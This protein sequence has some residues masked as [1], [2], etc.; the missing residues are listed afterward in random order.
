MTDRAAGPARAVIEQD[1]VVFTS[2]FRYNESVKAYYRERNPD[3]PQYVGTPAPEI[4]KA[5][6]ELLMGM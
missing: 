4:D 2:A 1:Q 3:Q 5:W 6:E